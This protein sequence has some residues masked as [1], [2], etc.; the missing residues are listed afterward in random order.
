MKTL[1]LTRWP[2]PQ[3]GQK[4][5]PATP[6]PKGRAGGG[7]VIP[8]AWTGAVI[9]APGARELTKDS[10]LRLDRPQDAEAVSLEV[11]SGTVWLTATPADRDILLQA[12]ESLSLRGPWPM[13]LQ[14]LTDAAVRISPMPNGQM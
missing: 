12:G 8:A 2:A 7:P 9:P 4:T 14:A 3:S 1:A 6:R 13:I 11:R 5:I 10:I